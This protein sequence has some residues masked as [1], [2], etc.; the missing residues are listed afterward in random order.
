MQKYDMLKMY[1]VLYVKVF[2]RESIEAKKQGVLLIM[3]KK[4]MLSLY[5]CI[6]SA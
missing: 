5:T 4:K 6:L 2:N 3:S 1:Y